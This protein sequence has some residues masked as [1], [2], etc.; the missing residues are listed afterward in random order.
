MSKADLYL[1][2]LQVDINIRFFIHLLDVRIIT[3][4]YIKST[5]IYEYR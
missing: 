1:N 3:H 5:R 4:L 2:R